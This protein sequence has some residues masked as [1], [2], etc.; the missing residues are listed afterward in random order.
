MFLTG[1]LLLCGQLVFDN[2]AN[3]FIAGSNI[4]KT[5]SWPCLLV[6]NGR[7]ERVFRFT[8]VGEQRIGRTLS[9]PSTNSLNTFSLLFSYCVCLFVCLLA[10]SFLPS[11]LSFFHHLLPSILCFHCALYFILAVCI[12]VYLSCR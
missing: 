4:I 5:R 2:E 12:H 11:F 8:N 9:F 6:K 1:E 10:S 7:G 3:V